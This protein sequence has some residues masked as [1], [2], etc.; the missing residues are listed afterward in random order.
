[1]SLFD[2][3]KEAA[4]LKA[5]NETFWDVAF[6][7]TE[8][9]SIDYILGGGFAFGRVAE[10]FGNFS[11]GKTLILYAALIA[12]AKRGGVSILK[13]SEGAFDAKFYTRLGGDPSQLLVHRVDK[14]ED[15][16]NSVVTLCEAARDS[17]SKQPVVIGWDSLAATGT[18]HLMKEGMDKVDMSKAKMISQGFQL[19][20]TLLNETQVSFIVTN[21]TRETINSNDSATTTPG[22]KALPFHA[23]QRLELKYDGG[24]KTSKINAVD[25]KGGEKKTSD[26]FAVEIGRWI[27]AKCEKNKCGAPWGSCRLPI[28][29]K[30]DRQ[31]PEYDRRTVLGIDFDEA[32][33]DFYLHSDFRLPNKEKV[34]QT[35]SSGWFCLAT[36]LD[37]TQ[38]KFRYRDWPNVLEANDILRSLVYDYAEIFGTPL[39]P[40][41]EVPQETVPEVA[42]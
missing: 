27:V 25:E 36:V 33:F 15:V 39:P 7:R 24:S 14:V 10:L 32:L 35:P 13:E 28:Y 5:G 6:C 31:H 23:S 30:D 18:K 26:D 9:P 8:I 22:G 20:T 19:V 12:N 2:E 11:S 16:F 41:P 1:M 38:A 40:A 4:N 34:V 17:K 3:L 21:Q 42:T 37:P 29:A